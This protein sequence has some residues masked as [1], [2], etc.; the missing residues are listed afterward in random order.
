MEP[1]FAA[2]FGV[3]LDGVLDGAGVVVVEVSGETNESDLFVEGIDSIKSPSSSACLFFELLFDLNELAFAGLAGEG[4]ALEAFKREGE[5]FESLITSRS[6]SDVLSDSVRP[7]FKFYANVSAQSH[8]SIYQQ[9]LFA[10]NSTYKT[11]RRCSLC[12]LSV[13]T[14][15]CRHGISRK[16]GWFRK[17]AREVY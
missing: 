14:G 4:D 11:S 7:F 1:F 3:T 8:V 15:F 10:P 13:E 16:P 12:Q 6:L 17:A 9:V 5:R 2:L